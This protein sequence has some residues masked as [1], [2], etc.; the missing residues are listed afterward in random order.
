VSR[1][2]DAV[3]ASVRDGLARAMSLYNRSAPNDPAT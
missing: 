1:A 2:A 3:E